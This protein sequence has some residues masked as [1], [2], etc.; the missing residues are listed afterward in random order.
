MFTPR[1]RHLEY[2]KTWI[3]LDNISAICR[4]AETILGGEHL[5]LLSVDLDGNDWYI[6]R[7]VLRRLAPAVIVV[8]Y[9]AKFP[10]PVDFV[11]DYDPNH[12]WTV[13]DY[14]GASLT[15]WDR[16]LHDRYRL[17]CCNY[18]GCNAFFVRR[19]RAAAFEDVPENLCELFVPPNHVW[20][21]RSG[22]PVSPK[23]LEMFS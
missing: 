16:L 18:T 15:A 11:I 2:L 3:T 6:V 8:E 10:P 20:F 19:D 12:R 7:E 23:T 4:H 9:N 14:F 22:H 1:G 21:I 5:D 13:D 17:V